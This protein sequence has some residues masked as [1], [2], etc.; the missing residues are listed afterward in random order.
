MVLCAKSSALTA[1]GD[2]VRTSIG[3]VSLPATALRIVGVLC[4]ACA[5]GAMT[6]AEAITGI[7][8][9]KISGIKSAPSNIELPLA[10][11]STLT[12]GAVVYE[13]KVWPLVMENVA[14]STIEFWVTMDMA[15]TGTLKARGIVIYEE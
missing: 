10:C 5:A 7:F 12:N 6:T 1:T 14:N 13:P 9:L 11:I 15:Q 3:S 2:T 4:Y 8:D